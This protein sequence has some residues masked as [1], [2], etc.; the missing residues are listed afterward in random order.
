MI[1][2]TWIK[3]LVTPD[4]PIPSMMWFLG[5]GLARS[6]LINPQFLSNNSV[7][8]PKRLVKRVVRAITPAPMN[9]R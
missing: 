7:M 2:I 1:T 8:P 4:R 3:D 5:M 9:V 6:S